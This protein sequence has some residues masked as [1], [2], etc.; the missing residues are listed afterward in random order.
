MLEDLCLDAEFAI[1]MNGFGKREL[2]VHTGLL[3][4]S[5]YALGITGT[6]HPHLIQ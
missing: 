6:W 2:F 4:H 5:C 1:A 3:A